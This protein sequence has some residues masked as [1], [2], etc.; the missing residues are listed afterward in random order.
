MGDESRARRAKDDDGKKRTPATR[1]AA[2]EAAARATRQLAT[3]LRDQ[4]LNDDADRVAYQAQVLQRT[5]LRRQ[6]RLGAWAFSLL[7]WAP[8]GYGHRIGR[9]ALTYLLVVSTFAAAFYLLGAS[10]GQPPLT[11]TGAI[12][13]SLTN[14][15]GR[16]FT[17]QFVLD[18]A[19]AWLAAIQPV[20]GIVIEGAFVA[21]LVQRF[22]GR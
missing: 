3:V 13:L 18:T 12:Q 4:G 19:Q 17:G 2:F 5:V 7:L 14:I 15:H 1:L 8:A 6:G 20:L 21:M 9:I 11:V 16:V 10:P 22:F